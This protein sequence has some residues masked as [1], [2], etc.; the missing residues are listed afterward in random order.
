MNAMTS[1]RVQRSFSRSFQSYHDSAGQQARIAQQLAQR[2]SD[3]GAPNSYSSVFEIGCGTGHLTEALH[4]HFSLENVILNDLMP[5]AS[6]TAHIWGAEFRSGD[7]RNVA[8]P[9]RQDLI[10]STSTIQWLDTP[11]DVVANAARSLAPGG[12][13]AISGFGQDQYAELVHLGSGSRAPGLCGPDVLAQALKA[14]GDEMEIV[15]L[16][17]ERRKLW[18]DTPQ[19]VLRHLRKTGVNGRAA[20]VWTRSTLAAFCEDYNR[21]F[22][23]PQGVSLTYHPVWVIARK[24]P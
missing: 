17:Q 16:W 14:A 5:E 4:Q 23:T 15:D 11:Q 20:Q 3:L 12:W 6:E 1:A 10:V 8:W 7:I 13:L 18:F 22:A 21:A 2:L 9:V 19:H 24:R